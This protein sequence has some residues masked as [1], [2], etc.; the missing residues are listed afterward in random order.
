[1]IVNTSVALLYVC[2][3]YFIH[4]LQYC[5]SSNA[6]SL[7]TASKFPIERN[8]IPLPTS[9]ALNSVNDPINFRVLQFNILA[10]GLSGRREDRGQFSR[11]S[12][13]DVL[14]WNVRK[15]KL[16][17]EITQYQPDVITL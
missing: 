10:D 4:V 13:P 2:L 16:I 6:K 17:R 14:D 8:F 15:T 1:M 11:I 5:N 3:L 12:S 9:Y 7:K